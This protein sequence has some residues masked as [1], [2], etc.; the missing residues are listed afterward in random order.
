MVTLPLDGLSVVDATSRRAGSIAGMLLADLGAAVTRI[1]TADG[2]HRRPAPGDLPDAV[3]W[4]RG[5]SS[6]VVDSFD[7]HTDPTLVPDSPP[8]SGEPLTRS[9]PV[10]A[11]IATR[12]IR[13]AVAASTM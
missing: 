4:D 6:L 2:R 5:K 8:E 10:T 9:I 11:S 1:E 3:C 12:K 13:S 7:P